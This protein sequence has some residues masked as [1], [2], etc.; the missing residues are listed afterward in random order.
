[1]LKPLA[2]NTEDCLDSSNETNFLTESFC[3]C[4]QNQGADCTILLPTIAQREMQ[5]ASWDDSQPSSVTQ[6]LHRSRVVCQEIDA[7][8]WVY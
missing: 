8:S 6:A 2:T 5:K 1:M 4:V 7:V 3:D